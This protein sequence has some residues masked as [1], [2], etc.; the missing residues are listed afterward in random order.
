MRNYILLTITL[1]NFS[2]FAQEPASK[3]S[4]DRYLNNV[5]KIEK[6]DRLRS[7][8]IDAIIEEDYQKIGKYVGELRAIEGNRYI[9]LFPYE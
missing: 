1:L 5:S 8:M 3:D 4:T 9:G 2:I 6:I 7:L